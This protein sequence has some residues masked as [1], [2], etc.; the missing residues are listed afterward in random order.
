MK[1]VQI[2][3]YLG[4]NAIEGTYSAHGLKTVNL[5]RKLLCYH[6]QDLNIKKY[7]ELLIKITQDNVLNMKE[8]AGH[9]I[10]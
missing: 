6:Q 5:T 10:S 4:Y 7:I 8:T 2:L 1:I 9:Q 3:V